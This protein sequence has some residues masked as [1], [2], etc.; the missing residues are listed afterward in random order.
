MTDRSKRAIIT[1]VSH[2]LHKDICQSVKLFY[3]KFSIQISFVILPRFIKDNCG[4]FCCSLNFLGE[5]YICQTKMDSC[6][7]VSQGPK[8][9]YFRFLNRSQRA[10]S[11]ANHFVFKSPNLGFCHHTT[12]QTVTAPCTVKLP[13][14]LITVTL[15]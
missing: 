5:K 6:A 12:A 2:Y 15:F 7:A 8:L 1:S 10:N 11:N 3:F 9:K 13:E 4:Y 14:K